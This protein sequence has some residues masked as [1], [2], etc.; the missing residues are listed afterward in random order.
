MLW[1]LAVDLLAGACCVGCRSPGRVLCAACA[2]GLDPAGARPAPPDPC[3]PGLAPV[4]ACADYQGAVKAMVNGYKERAQHGLRAPLAMLLAGSVAAACRDP[5]APLVLCPVPSRPSVVRR[6]GQD[7]SYALAAAAARGLRRRGYDVSAR[8]LLVVRGAV[9]DQ[10]GLTAGDRFANLAGT[11]ACPPERL[12]RLAAWRPEVRVIV[13]DD[14]ITTGATVA[15]AQRALAAVGLP[16]RAIATVAA[17][18][19]RRAS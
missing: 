8:R 6:R 13:C 3:P 14:V 12:H 18:V 16:V 17:T 15:E 4:W 2:A 19:R 10:A 11:L 9:R 5:A 7:A 1:D